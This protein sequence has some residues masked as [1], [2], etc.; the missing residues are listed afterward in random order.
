VIIDQRPAQERRLVLG[1]AVEAGSR[2]HAEVAERVAPQLPLRGLAGD[3]DRRLAGDQEVGVGDADEQRAADARGG[4]AGPVE[5]L[6]EREARGDLV[7]PGG[8]RRR[9][10]GKATERVGGGGDG[11]R[12]RETAKVAQ[13]G[14][15]DDRADPVAQ[16]G[17][18]QAGALGERNLEQLGQAVGERNLRDHGGDPLVLG[19]QAHDVAT[20]ARGAP[21]GDPLGIDAVE[22]AGEGDRRPPVVELG[23]VVVELAWLALAGA[24]E[25]VVEDE[26]GDPGGGEALGVGV[27]ALLA[28][29]VEAVRDDDQWAVGWIPRAVVPGGAGLPVRCE[30]DVVARPHGRVRRRRVVTRG[31]GGSHGCL[32]CRSRETPA[33]IHANRLARRLVVGNSTEPPWRRCYIQIG[34]FE[35]PWRTC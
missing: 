21:E 35:S 8:L 15:A 20:R 19:G 24:E 22:P 33:R 9:Q 5:G 6:G 12:A 30:C 17:G 34:V 32:S 18:E 14:A 3:A 25:A 31:L 27:E 7:A 23:A 4:P 13:A 16:P 1:D 11:E 28:D 2:V 26:R 29:A 10:I